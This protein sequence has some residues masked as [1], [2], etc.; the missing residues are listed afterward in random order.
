MNISIQN[1]TTVGAFEHNN[2]VNINLTVNHIEI[3]SSE[4]HLKELNLYDLRGKKIIALDLQNE[5]FMDCKKFHC[6]EP[7]GIYIAL[8]TDSHGMVHRKKLYMP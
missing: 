1:M 7:S 8:I 4:N 3:C 6:A 2:E 5:N